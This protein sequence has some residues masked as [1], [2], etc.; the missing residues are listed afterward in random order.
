MNEHYPF[1]LA[2]LPYAHDALEPYID[3]RTVEIHHGRHQKNYVDNLNKA[4]CCYPAYQCWPLEK[5]LCGTLAGPRQTQVDIL[6]NAGGVYA[7]ELYF[8]GM[9]PC[10]HMDRPCGKLAEAIDRCFCSFEKF[11]D[12][13]TQT[14]LSQFGSG[15]AW[16]A[17]CP[18]CSLTILS[19]CNQETPIARG[20]RP[21]LCVDV[22]EHAY[23]LQYQNLR[24]EY[25]EAWWNLVDWEFAEKNY[26]AQGY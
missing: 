10:P 8:D 25:L 3:A 13:F 26:L 23:Y 18:D 17:V 12:I 15:W 5:L 4:L 9:A 2:P 14:A 22:W 24:K 16:L 7:H 1:E 6:R 20:M 11:R 21:V 19:T